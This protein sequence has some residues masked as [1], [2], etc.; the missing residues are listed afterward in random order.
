[1]K[2]CGLLGRGLQPSLSRQGGGN[3]V[4]PSTNDELPIINRLFPTRL[5]MHEKELCGQHI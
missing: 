4:N 2:K 3:A 5:A 1:L